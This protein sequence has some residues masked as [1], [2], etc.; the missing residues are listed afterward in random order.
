MLTAEKAVSRELMLSQQAADR[1]ALSISFEPSEW[2]LCGRD[3]GLVVADV[4]NVR[5]AASLTAPVLTTL[6]YGASVVIWATC[7][8]WHLVQDAR[9][10]TGWVASQWIQVS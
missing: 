8:G 10:F 4:L 1:Q 2:P 7:N 6:V 9:G 3:V 5:Q